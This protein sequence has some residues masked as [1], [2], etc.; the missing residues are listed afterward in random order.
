MKPELTQIELNE[1]EIKVLNI[2]QRGHKNAMSLR[3]LV[4]RTSSNERKLR[5]AIE[6]LRLQ[7]YLIL[8]AQ[9]EKI[10]IPDHKRKLVKFILPSGYFL[11]ETIDEVEAF[12]AYM[13]SRVIAECKIMW[14]MKV[15]SKKYFEKQ[16]GQIPLF[17][18]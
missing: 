18:G 10:Y 13:K 15:A 4:L 2:L 7:G 16:F 6:T 9:K 12:R 8:F 17:M 5:L 1:L 3:D 11:A 14:A